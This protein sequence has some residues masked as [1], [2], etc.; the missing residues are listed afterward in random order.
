MAA[1]ISFLFLIDPL[2]DLRFHGRYDLTIG[3]TLEG[4]SI[5]LITLYVVN[6]PETL[7]GRVLNAAFLRHI[8]VMSY[9]IYLWQNIMT[10][11]AGRYFPFNLVAIIAIAELSYWA[12]ERPFLRLRNSLQNRTSVNLEPSS[13][14]VM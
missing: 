1:A 8:G 4:V 7:P 13:T 6:R 2:L 10:A 11:E 9:S 3:M 12:V 14:S 5:S